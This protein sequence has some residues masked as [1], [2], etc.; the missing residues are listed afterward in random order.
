MTKTEYMT[1]INE[2]L[3]AAEALCADLRK[4]RILQKLIKDFPCPRC[5]RYAMDIHP[6][7]NALSR[8][9]GVHIC[10]E[11]GMHEAVEDMAGGFKL[12]LSS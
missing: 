3:T 2:K 4:L 12:P 11:C 5:G 9:A 1:T 7:R 8:R 6:A 10:D